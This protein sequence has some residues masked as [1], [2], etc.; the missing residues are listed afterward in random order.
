MGLVWEL[1]GIPRL[2]LGLS[3]GSRLVERIEQSRT[4][5]K[6]RRQ[7]Q[8][9]CE[10]FWR[11][12]LL[13]RVSES[14]VQERNRSE[15]TEERWALILGCSSGFGAA[16]GRELAG[17]GFH[18]C[19]VHLDRRATLDKVEETKTAIEAEGVRAEF[20]N[21]NA[22]D[23][24]KREEVILKLSTFASPGSVRL[25]FHSLA[26][27]SLVPL[28]GEEPKRSA[29]KNHIDMT[30]DVMASSLVY[31]TQELIWSG[32]MGEGGRVLAMSSSGSTRAMASYGIVSA[33]KAALEAYIRQL[34]LELA[35]LGMTANTIRAGVTDTAALRKIPGWE[36]VKERAETVNPHGR[37]TEPVDVARVVALLVEPGASWI[38]G[39]V[40]GVDGAEDVVG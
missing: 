20:F 8:T 4:L 31:W 1:S 11:V 34:A 26:F 13:G 28:V 6:P 29:K 27:G 2:A 38:S 32:L 9:A 40:I 35:P 16:V 24:G 36:Q 10:R 39:N 7:V 5:A 30:L 17:K 22:A 25:L 33:A 21:V 14:D 37:L 23:P 12:L 18:I 15:S 3:L 19:G